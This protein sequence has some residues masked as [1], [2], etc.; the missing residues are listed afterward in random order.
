MIENQTRGICRDNLAVANLPKRRKME[1]EEV[2]IQ[3]SSSL[4]DGQD[5]GEKLSRG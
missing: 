3:T 4:V 2:D 5:E 1:A